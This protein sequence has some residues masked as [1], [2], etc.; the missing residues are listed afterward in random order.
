M[1]VK[2]V[3]AVRAVEYRVWFPVATNASIAAA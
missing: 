3:R 1:A 2:K